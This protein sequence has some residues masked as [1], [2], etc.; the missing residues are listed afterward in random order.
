MAVKLTYEI[1]RAELAERVGCKVLGVKHGCALIESPQLYED[2][3]AVS[4]G[5]CYVAESVPSTSSCWQSDALFVVCG[6]GSKTYSKR[7]QGEW[8]MLCFSKPQSQRQVMNILLDVFTKYRRW[9]EELFKTLL[10]SGSLNALL[11]LSLPV[12]ENPLFLIDS[13]FYLVAEASPDDALDLDRPMRKVDEA[14]IVRG[15]DELLNAADISTPFFR[16]LSDDY[17]RLFINLLEGE[18][19]LGNLSIQASRRPLRESDEYLLA[20]L[21]GIVHT[22]MLRS[23][24]SDDDWR[25]H[26][27]RMLSEVIAGGAVD[28]EEFNQALS[29]LGHRGGD[30]FRCLTIRIPKPSGREFIRN[31]LQLLGTQIPTMYIPV[32]GEI[33]VMIMS[34]SMAKRQGFEAVPWMEEKMGLLGFR[35]GLSDVYND[36]LLTRYYF[37]QARYALQRG[38]A[39]QTAKSVT[40]FSECCLDY[41]LENVSGDLRPDML[42]SEGFRKLIEHD[43]K[44]RANYVETLRAYLNNN[45]NTHRAAAALYISR[46]SLLAQLERINVL[47]KEDLKDPEV[48]F[49]Y[50]LSLLLYDLTS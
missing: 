48:R 5:Y 17:P 12:L 2:G 45:L 23:V 32:S 22:A 6:A 20:H 10:E 36:L 27:G 46:N 9:T 21:A 15:K 42:W 28:V 3:A 7:T 30:Q 14:W 1:L 50:E 19:L 44:G 33:A 47:L 24:T 26:A 49:R 29:H 38:E 41:I 31:F 25:G 43:E 37:A 39:A 13:R 8:G 40:L 18:Y 35:V 16:H 11:R 4:D 34:V